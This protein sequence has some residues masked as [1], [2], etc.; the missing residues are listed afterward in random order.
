MAKGVWP[1]NFP[2]VWPST[3][4][5]LPP[6]VIHGPLTFFSARNALAYNGDSTGGFSMDV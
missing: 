5:S 2:G 1:K 3:T 4:F 6:A